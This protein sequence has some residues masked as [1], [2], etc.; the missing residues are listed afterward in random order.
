MLKIWIFWDENKP[1]GNPA[2]SSRPDGTRNLARHLHRL[3][4][5]HAAR[6]GPHHVHLESRPGQGSREGKLFL[7][8]FIQNI[9]PQGHS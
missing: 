1:S 9:T 7:N 5:D 2:S 8:T 3:S 4:A 6:A